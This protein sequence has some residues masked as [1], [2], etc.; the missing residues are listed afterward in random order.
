M[1]PQPPPISSEWAVNHHRDSLATVIGH[2]DMLVYA[3]AA[4]GVCVARE[5]QKLMEKM[6]EPCGPPPKRS[7]AAV[8]LASAMHAATEASAK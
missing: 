2:H 4:E 1:R 8:L 6:I 3:A 5:R 7:P